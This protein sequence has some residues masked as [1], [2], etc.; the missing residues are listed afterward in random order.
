[1]LL[2]LNHVDEVLPEIDHII[3]LDNGRV[4]ADGPKAETLTTKTLSALYRRPI[5]LAQSASGFFRV[6]VV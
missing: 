3:L 6:S 2:E 1:M 5:E 4:V